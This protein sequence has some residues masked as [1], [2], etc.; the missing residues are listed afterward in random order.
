MDSQ[1]ISDRIS[2]LLIALSSPLTA[3]EEA[4]GCHQRANMQLAS[5]CLDFSPLWKLVANF[6]RS[7]LRAVS[8]I[9]A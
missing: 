7:A 5:I 9:G 3:S 2:E 8:I 6:P 4:D 1:E